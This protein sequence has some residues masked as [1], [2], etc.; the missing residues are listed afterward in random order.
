MSQSEFTVEPFDLCERHAHFNEDGSVSLIKSET[1]WSLPPEEMNAQFGHLLVSVF[2][3][4]EN[5]PT[6]EMHPHGDEMVYLLSGAATL[7]LRLPHGD[8]GIA[9]TANRGY[10]IP[11]GVWHTAHTEVPCQALFITRGQ[12]TQIANAAEMLAKY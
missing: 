8:I 12:D 7:I 9:L 10:L 11:K 5:W 1:L 4:S 2:S 3:F 6:W